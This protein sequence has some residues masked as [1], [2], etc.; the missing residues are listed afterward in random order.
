[1][2]SPVGGQYIFFEPDGTRVN[3]ALTA[4]GSDLPDPVAGSV[5][6]EI[7][8]NAPGNLAAGYQG[9]AFAPGA[10]L[11]DSAVFGASLQLLAGTYAVMG[12]SVI[13]LGSGEQKVVAAVGD[14]VTGGSGAGF[15]DA[16]AG[17][18]A[19][20]IGSAGGSDTIFSGHSDTIRGGADNATILGAAGDM[21]DLA[22]STG[23]GFINAMAGRES[24]VLGSG[25]ATVLGAI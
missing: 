3:L 9:S 13:A 18:I 2:A 10:I 8:T 16:T 14:T 5:N 21:I 11:S 12:G 7:F 23:T 6:I 22:G 19:A 20:Q 15:I 17:S 24:V 25:A 1:M 4:D